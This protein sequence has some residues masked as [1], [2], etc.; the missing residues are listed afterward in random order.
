MKA[1]KRVASML[2]ALMMTGSFAACGDMGGLGGGS[3]GGGD[4]TSND[5]GS[6]GGGSTDSGNSTGGGSIGG[7]DIGGILDDVIN[8]EFSDS[9]KQ[10]AAA[11]D[12]TLAE[13]KSVKIS[14]EMQLLENAFDDTLGTVTADIVFTDDNGTLSMMINATS[15]STEGGVSYTEYADVLMKEG[16]LY[17][18]SYDANDPAEN[19][20]WRRSEAPIIPTDFSFL[21]EEPEVGTEEG[22]PSMMVFIQQIFATKE[23]QD[24]MAFLGD[25]YD[26]VWMSLMDAGTIED[27]VWSMTTDF[28]HV[29]E[30]WNDYA[31]IINEGTMTYGEFVE[32]FFRR[33]GVTVSYDQMINDVSVLVSK[34]VPEAIDILETFAQENFEMSLQELKDALVN[35]EL[36]GVVMN[37]MV[38]GDADAIAAIKAW[39]V[40]TLKND[41]TLKA[42][43]LKD[44][45]N[46]AIESSQPQED[47]DVNGD[48][49][50]DGGYTE[51][52]KIET[53]SGEITDG[54]TDGSEGEE[55]ETQPTDYVAQY[56]AML[57]Q[58]KSTTLAEMEMYMPEIP[59]SNVEALT[60]TNSL[61]FNEE[62]TKV[63]GAGVA[64]AVDM[65]VTT[66]VYDYETDSYVSTTG[67]IKMAISLNV[68]EFA[69]TAATVTAPA[70]GEYEEVNNGG[71]ND[72][73][74]S[75]AVRVIED[76]N[77]HIEFCQEFVSGEYYT[78]EYMVMFKE[79]AQD[80]PFTYG[81]TIYLSEVKFVEGVEQELI[82]AYLALY[83][84]YDP[85]VCIVVYE[86][87]SYNIAISL[88]DATA[89]EESLVELPTLDE[90]G[91][92][93]AEKAE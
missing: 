78:G 13:T 35:T 9:A 49:T 2:M 88:W 82:D 38:G 26:A 41:E 65:D 68:D 77:A 12:A 70:E 15:A 37:M 29:I 19:K 11:V 43:T 45:I 14:A 46:M 89:E 51:N 6:T 44:L 53:M 50:V 79:Y 20:I 17:A 21:F 36:A 84:E 10:Y 18:R 73:G 58:M 66:E 28:A 87:G 61:T 39:Q 31:A 52:E 16:Y 56:I 63:T 1:W 57:T 47:T 81:E 54:A 76:E 40:D 80:A 83:A 30:Y 25:A 62:G 69:T 48:P 75:M 67:G 22:A 5:T 7:G 59:V 3:T 64:F 24:V 93:L 42:M 72:G 92:A 34:T 27:N 4:T 90:I 55:V 32:D 23:M 8:G 85:M 74:S 91:K 71:V 33:M 86:D 60:M